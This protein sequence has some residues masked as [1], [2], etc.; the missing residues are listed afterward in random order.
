MTD[1]QFINVGM[2]DLVH[3]SYARALIWVL[4]WELDVNLP[5]PSCERRC[6][7]PTTSLARLALHA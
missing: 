6:G 1:S 5:N 2:K 7:R 4:L 3:E